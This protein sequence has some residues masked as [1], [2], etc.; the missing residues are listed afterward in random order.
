MSNAAEAEYEFAGLRGLGLAVGHAKRGGAGG[1]R[2][3]WRVKQRSRSRNLPMELRRVG[4]SRHLGHLQRALQIL[5]SHCQG[6]GGG[7]GL[8]ASPIDSGSLVVT[9]PVLSSSR[10]TT[11][12]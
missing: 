8:L 12:S 2:W 6:T 4:P 1:P 3:Q 10:I 9:P 7:F 5:L 11:N